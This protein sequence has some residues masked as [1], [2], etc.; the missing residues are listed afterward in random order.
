M[1]F[2][3]QGSIVELLRLVHPGMAVVRFFTSCGSFEELIFA[4]SLKPV[5]SPIPED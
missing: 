3:Y 4:D 2:D 1:L 5:A